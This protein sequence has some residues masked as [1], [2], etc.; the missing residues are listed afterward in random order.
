M[1]RIQRGWKVWKALARAIGDVVARILLTIFYGLVFA[2][3]AIGVRLRGDPL[4]LKG[5]RRLQWNRRT[6]F[7]ERLDQA[8]KLF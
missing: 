1:N 2:P 6:K 8:R 7:E 5:A 3:V 4:G